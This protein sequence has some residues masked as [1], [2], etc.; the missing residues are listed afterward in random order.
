MSI[1][2]RDKAS[3]RISNRAPDVAPFQKDFLYKLLNKLC[4]QT[5]I[6]FVAG[7]YQQVNQQLIVLNLSFACPIQGCANVNLSRRQ[8]RGSLQSNLSLWKQFSKRKNLLD[9]WLKA[10]GSSQEP[11]RAGRPALKYHFQVWTH[12]RKTMII[13]LP[14]SSILFV[15][16]CCQLNGRRPTVWTSERLLLIT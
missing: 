2:C 7:Y 8:K 13:T 15:P 14:A 3:W 9:S 1:S 10:Q 12:I 5:L 16:I 11:S 4:H 6:P